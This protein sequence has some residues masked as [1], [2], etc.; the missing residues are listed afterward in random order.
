MEVLRCLGMKDALREQH[1]EEILTRTAVYR[2]EGTGRSEAEYE[3][4]EHHRECQHHQLQYRRPHCALK[5]TDVVGYAHRAH[6]LL[7]L[8]EGAVLHRGHVVHVD[9]VHRQKPEYS[10]KG[11]REKGEID[12]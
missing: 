1:A 7:P 3:K 8:H 12:E 6:G 5:G 9:V 4:G 2:N 11:I 10:Q